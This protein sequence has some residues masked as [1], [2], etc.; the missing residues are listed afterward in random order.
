[1]STV[2]V[3]SNWTMFLK[4]MFPLMWIVFFG[5][6]TVLT[7]LS[8]PFESSGMLSR[9][10]IRILIASFFVTSTGLI[11]LRTMYLKRVDMDDE[12]IYVTNYFSHRRYTHDSIEKI[13]ERAGIMAKPF[14]ITFKE[15]GFFGKGITFL[16]SKKFEHFLVE[17]PESAKAWGLV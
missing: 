10:A 8:E 5:S 4:L 15:K 12:Y 2:N 17:H 13:E 11:L 14:V 16:S 1:M 7:I 6:L 3:S 9:Q